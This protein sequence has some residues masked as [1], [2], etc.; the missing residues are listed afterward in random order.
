MAKKKSNATI[1]IRF[2]DENTEVDIDGFEKISPGKIQRSFDFVLAEWHTH[3][4]KAIQG[5]RRKDQEAQRED[6]QDAA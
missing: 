5:K 4:Q 6:E 3:Q 1:I 2:F